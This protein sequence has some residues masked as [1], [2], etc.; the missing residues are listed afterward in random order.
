MTTPQHM[1]FL[2]FKVGVTV[3]TSNSTSLSACCL[4]SATGWQYHAAVTVV[5]MWYVR[6]TV[7]FPLALNSSA[8]QLVHCAY[9]YP[10]PTPASAIDAHFL[11]WRTC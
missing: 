5:V 6:H 8:V 7:H 9:I 3:T 2:I 11:Q 4:A 1:A 10:A